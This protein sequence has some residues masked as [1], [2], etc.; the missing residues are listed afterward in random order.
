VRTTNNIIALTCPTKR[1]E[2][3]ELKVSASRSD[4]PILEINS[5]GSQ[6]KVNVHYAVLLDRHGRDYR[7][8]S[9]KMQAAK[10]QPARVTA[11]TRGGS[12]YVAQTG[13]AVPIEV[14]LE[15]VVGKQTKKTKLKFTPHAAG[16]VIRIRPTDWSS[17]IKK[18]VIDRM[19][20]LSGGVLGRIKKTGR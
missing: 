17:S 13:R 18:I 3:D 10:N 1:N 16:E 9:V 4:R 5:K 20:S 11:S 19:S 6:K 12:I 15:A 7:R 2:A 8:F 14:N